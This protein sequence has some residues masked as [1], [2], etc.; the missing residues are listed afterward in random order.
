L[1]FEKNTSPERVASLPMVDFGFPGTGDIVE[2]WAQ[3]GV[4]GDKDIFEKNTSPKRY[5]GLRPGHF[6]FLGKSSSG[7]LGK[8]CAQLPLAED[9]NLQNDYRHLSVCHS[10]VLQGCWCQ[11]TIFF[12]FF[13]SGELVNSSV[14]AEK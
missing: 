6:C 9:I 1:N 3:L 5:K 7:E 12:G 11:C 8:T 13:N 4:E 10:P 2:T 14:R